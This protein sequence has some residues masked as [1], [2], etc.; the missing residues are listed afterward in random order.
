VG[1][2]RIRDRVVCCAPGVVVDARERVALG[3]AITITGVW[4]LVVLFAVFYGESV[5][6]AVHLAMMGVV[7]W[8]TT[9]LAVRRGERNGKPPPSEGP[10]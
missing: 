4:V 9:Y 1:S 7:G 6:P 5:D 3:I 10:A 2:I 8:I